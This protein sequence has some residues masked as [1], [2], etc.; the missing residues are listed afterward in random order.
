MRARAREPLVEDLVVD[1]VEHPDRGIT[2][3]ELDRWGEAGAT[4]KRWGALKDGMTLTSVACTA[5]DDD[6]FVELEYDPSVGSWYHYCT[7]TGLVRVDRDDLMTYALDLEWLL[8]RLAGLLAIHRLEATPLIDGV[9]WRLGTARIETRFWTAVL[10]RDVERNLNAILEQVQRSGREH[11]GLLLSSSPTTPRNI[12]LPNDHRWLPLRDLLEA[13]SG[14]LA[15]RATAIMDALR[16]RKRDGPAAKAGRPGVEKVI[17]A[18]LRRRAV[19]GEMLHRV[20]DEARYLADWLRHAP[21]SS[22]RSPGRV[23]NIIRDA[24]YELKGKAP[25]PTK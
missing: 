21:R 22:E 18:E 11:P 24:F 12:A 15:V 20:R 10:V 1:L 5:C 13:E 6:H 14:D 7:W 17:L 3:R 8:S 4:L 23:E 25:R 2:R 9:M 16:V 19:T